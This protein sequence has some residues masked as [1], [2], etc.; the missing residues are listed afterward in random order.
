MKPHD[1]NDANK[2]MEFLLKT[3]FDEEVIAMDCNDGCEQIAALA[4]RVAR[5]ESLDSIQPEFQQHMHYWKDCREEF[6]ALVALIKAEN[7]GE[8]PDFIPEDL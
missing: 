7:N 6:D 4:E 2:L 5:G 8:L 3:P 1:E